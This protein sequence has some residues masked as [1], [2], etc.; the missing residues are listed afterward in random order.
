MKNIYIINALEFYPFA[1]GKLNGALVDKAKSNLKNKGYEIQ[2]TT[3]K[4]DYDVKGE[5]EK[6]Q[7]NCMAR[8]NM[9]T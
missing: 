5:I 2:L 1:K 8:K 7:K 6:L 9:N 3:M 4:D